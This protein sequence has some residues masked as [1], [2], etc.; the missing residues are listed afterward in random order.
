M[1]DRDEAPSTVWSLMAFGLVM[2]C[3]VAFMVVSSFFEARAFNAV[4][5]KNVSTW[6]A[7]WIELRVQEGPK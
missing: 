1:S 2:V 4:T 5:G 6:D 7:M 3:V